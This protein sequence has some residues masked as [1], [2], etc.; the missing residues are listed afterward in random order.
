LK[1]YLLDADSVIAMKIEGGTVDERVHT[2]EKL[3]RGGPPAFGFNIPR[4]AV[5]V[6][7]FTELMEVAR[8]GHSYVC[9]T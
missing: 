4:Y 1:K 9:D 6:K 3:S 5:F 2:K 7:P 8:G